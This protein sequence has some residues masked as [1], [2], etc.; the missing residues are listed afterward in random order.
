MRS[1]EF[2][3]VKKLKINNSGE[4]FS[5]SRGGIERKGMSKFKRFEKSR[6]K[7]FIC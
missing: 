5:V 2:L 3:N 1:K 4:G 7:Y 6:L